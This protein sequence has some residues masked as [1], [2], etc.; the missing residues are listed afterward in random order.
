MCYNLRPSFHPLQLLRAAGQFVTQ[1]RYDS[2][3]G[4][5]LFMADLKDSVE[6]ARLYPIGDGRIVTV[7]GP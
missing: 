1:H 4:G 5:M 7:Y 2:G 3:P 6:E